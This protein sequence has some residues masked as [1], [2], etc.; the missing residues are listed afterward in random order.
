MIL[1]YTNH[2]ISMILTLYF[3]FS[4]LFHFQHDF[5]FPGRFMALLFV[6]VVIGADVSDRPTLPCQM[7]LAK[8]FTVNMALVD[9]CFLVWFC[10]HLKNKTYSLISAFFAQTVEDTG[11]F[12]LGVKDY[13]MEVE[14]K[15]V[16]AW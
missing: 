1:H 9:K 5:V 15:Q 4:T 7:E 3:R 12:V 14:K 11:Y 8:I 16:L 6:L 2:N 10:S 13:V